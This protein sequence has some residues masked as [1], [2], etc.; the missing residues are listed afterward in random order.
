MIKYPLLVKDFIEKISEL[1]TALS[2][3]SVHE[4][5]LNILKTRLLTDVSIQLNYVGLNGSGAPDPLSR[6]YT[7]QF[8][9]PV[10]PIAYLNSLRDFNIWKLFIEE[11]IKSIFINPSI[12]GVLTATTPITLGTFKLL[13]DQTAIRG[14]VLDG[15]NLAEFIS[16]VPSQNGKWH[17]ERLGMFNAYNVISNDIFDSLN[18]LIIPSSSAISTSPG[19]G[20]VTSKL[21]LI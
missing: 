6:A 9:E 12:E 13:F 2:R 10:L 21:I 4:L 20:I 3:A 5:L 8:L 19:S 14:A 7:G 17:G 1:G 15:R 11:Y 18:S 16:L